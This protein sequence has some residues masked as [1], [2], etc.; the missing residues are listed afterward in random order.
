MILQSEQGG[1]TR[2][3]IDSITAEKLRRAAFAH[4]EGN[5]ARA[6][7][8]CREIILQAAPHPLALYLL[9]SIASGQR[10]FEEADW[11]LGR[12]LSAEP[13]F[14]EAFVERGDVL[15]QLK[16]WDDA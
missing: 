13:D 12:A 4:R 8:L 2:G 7:Q 9:G 14:L 3:K 16:R 5:L 15:Q 11:L 6:E 1:T 10:R